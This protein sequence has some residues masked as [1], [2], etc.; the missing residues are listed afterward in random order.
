VN[1]MASTGMSV[2][3]YAYA[4]NNPVRYVD[5]N[6]L[7]PVAGATLGAEAGSLAGPA[8]AAAG[9]AVGA[10]LG[11]AVAAA[12]TST[13]VNAPPINWAGTEPGAGVPWPDASTPTIVATPSSSREVGGAGLVC[14]A[15]AKKKSKNDCVREAGQFY[16]ECLKY[17]DPRTCG[18]ERKQVYKACMEGRK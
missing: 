11:T 2:P 6:G 14:M 18:T 3:T 4:L 16:F 1:D 10:I 9:A 12:V 13:I 15:A 8:G 7:D 17:G 5:R